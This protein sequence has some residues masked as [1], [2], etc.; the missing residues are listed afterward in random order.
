MRPC[1]CCIP[2]FT[3]VRL[4]DRQLLAI[5]RPHCRPLVLG[6]R[7]RN[8]KEEFCVASEDCAFGPVGFQRIRDVAPGEMLIITGTMSSGQTFQTLLL[9]SCN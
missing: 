3:T 9:H 4:E 8:G 1:A 7:V 2:M 6:S 5:C